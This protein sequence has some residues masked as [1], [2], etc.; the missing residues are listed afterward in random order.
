MARD[1][2]DV[3]IKTTGPMFDPALLSHLQPIINNGLLDIAILEGSNKVKEQL[4]GP[5]T[6]P[7]YLASTPSERHGAYSRNLRNHVFARL[8]SNNITRVDTGGPTGG[9]DIVYASKVEAL[10]GMFANTKQDLNRNSVQLGDK[11]IGQPIIDLLNTELK[12]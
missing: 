11:Y 1:S 2:F 5:R 7:A 4:W 9:K 6:K 8:V 3:N 12:P 10:Y